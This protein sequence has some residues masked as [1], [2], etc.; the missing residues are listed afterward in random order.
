MKALIDGD[1]LV[2]W[3]ANWGQTNYFDVINSEGEVLDS[4][5]SKRFAQGSADDLM[6][7][8]NEEL[9][10]EAGDTRLT[11][12]KSCAEF[13]DNFITKI[14]RD[15]QCETFEVHLSGHTNFRKDISVTKP[16]KGN[17]TA[18]K[19]YYYQKVRNYLTDKYGAVV[20]VNEEADD[21]LA[22]AQSK[23]PDGTCICTVDK[24]LWMVPGNKYNFRKEEASYVTEFDGMR[25]MQFQMLAGDPVDNIQGVP[26]IGKVTADKLLA[27]NPG[28]DDAWV[29]IARAY[30]KA[31]GEVHK[32]VMVEMGRLLWM[33]RVENEMWNLPLI[34][35]TMEK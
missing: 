25:S 20:S 13:I 14:V 7:F 3:S 16:Y 11:K 28:I 21:T 19:P 34:I 30:K 1:V 9:T 24:D 31:Y 33:R 32:C 15:A 22:I 17:R 35:K 2:Y 5:E 29:A 6:D 10:V 26:K 4:R 27:A 12:W 8:G 23:D 18:E